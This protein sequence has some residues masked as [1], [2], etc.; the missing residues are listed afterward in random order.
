MNY[1]ELKQTVEPG[2]LELPGDNKAE[3]YITSFVS[4]QG[5]DPRDPKIASGL[6]EYSVGIN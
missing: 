5:K 4:K 6:F 1:I 2:N 3:L